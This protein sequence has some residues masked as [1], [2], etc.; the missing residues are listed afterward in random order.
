MQSGQ[1]SSK[2]PWHASWLFESQE[3][4]LNKGFPKPSGQAFTPPS[5]P[6]T[7]N[8]KIEEVTLINLSPQWRE[9]P[10]WVWQVLNSQT[11]FLYKMWFFW[12]RL[13]WMASYIGREKE[14]WFDCFRKKCCKKRNKWS[15]TRGGGTPRERQNFCIK[16]WIRTN[17]LISSNIQFITRF[18]SS[19]QECLKICKGKPQYEDP[20]LF[21]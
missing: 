14:D 19:V 2:V 16:K 1:I 12:T 20:P 13:S 5:L 18:A 17:I 4:G 7:G 21:V 10:F 15:Y 9:C 3:N 8:A 11:Q 6:P